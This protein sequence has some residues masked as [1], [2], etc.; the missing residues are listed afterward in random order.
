MPNDKIHV[1]QVIKYLD[2]SGPERFGINL[3]QALD[4]SVFDIKI[5]AFFQTNTDIEHYWTKY[6][7]DKGFSIT[8]AA[9]WKGNDQF[10][11]Y[12]N[13]IKSLKLLLQSWPVDIFHSHFQL[14]TLAGLYFRTTGQTRRVIRT[15]HNHSRKEWDPN[16][17]GW[18]RYQILSGWLY[19]MWLDAEIGVSQAITD[20]LRRHPGAH[21]SA[22]PPQTI[23]N[24]IPKDLIEQAQQISVTKENP[25][26]FIIGS[27]GRL[28]EQKG[29]PFLLQAFPDL[30]REFQNIELWLIGD[31]ELRE[32]LMEQARNLGI[33]DRVI[34]HGRKSD[35]LQW[36]RKMDLFVIP[37][38]WEGLPTVILEAMAAGVPVITTDIPGT[39]ELVE[40][41]VTGWLVPPRAALPLTR[42]IAYALH[43]PEM[44][45]SVSKN[46]LHKLEQFQIERIALQYQDLYFSLMK[47][48]NHQ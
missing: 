6:L 34:F 40:N 9:P 22:R 2:I 10:G 15:V 42:A 5:V 37:S 26:R 39:N 18:T 3:A 41:G 7:R 33:G 24:A 8:F 21:F 4:P 17:Y 45:Q 35:I 20:E 16:L 1:L 23:Y 27:V 32:S 29:Y 12:L 25:D 11:V 36:M 13:G 47:H 44:C 38:L 43:N 48:G 31:G 19:P 14:G 46:A 30:L 28:S